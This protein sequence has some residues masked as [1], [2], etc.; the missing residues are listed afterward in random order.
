MLMNLG[1]MELTI[2]QLETYTNL[3]YNFF[4]LVFFMKL[5]VFEYST[6]I[7]M[8]ELYDEG[9]NMLKSI[10]YDLDSLSKYEVDY[11]LHPD[12]TL[13]SFAN[14]RRLNVYDNLFDWLSD[15]VKFYEL[16]LF[17][18]PE[19]DFIQY[20]IT[21]II[22]EQDVVIIGSNSIA[23]GI[24]CSKTST[25]KHVSKDIS[26]IPSIYEDVINV[27]YDLIK[28]KLSDNVIIKPDNKTSSSYI[29]H[30]TGNDIPTSIL[31]QYEDADMDKC[32]FQ[33]YIKGRNVSVSSICKEDDI[34]I[35][36]INSQE[37]I[38]KDGKIRYQGCRSPIDDEKEEELRHMT[39]RI[40][41]EI[42]G[43]CGFVGIDYIIDG[44]NIYFVEINSRIT[45]PY[46]IL[47]KNC[48]RNLT[49]YLIN[50]VIN[51]KYNEE[52]NFTKEDIF[53]KR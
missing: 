53:L 43:L 17:I 31:K 20:N 19:D 34:K 26:K 18:A 23:S 44:E 27:D 46:I 9:L 37:I 51:D 5:L 2:R 13:E 29:Y 6:C 8:D 36:S 4:Y 33:K 47:A 24:C 48:D 10:L 16:V 45:T 30:L 28:S 15:N 12:I 40:I 25:Y 38:E 35:I 52:I 49:E 41:K 3:H 11:L 22:E 7:G 32:I 1:S 14:C 39:K 50:Y 42:P 21:K